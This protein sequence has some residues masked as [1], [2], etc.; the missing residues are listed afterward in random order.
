MWNLRICDITNLDIMHIL[1]ELQASRN[2]LVVAHRQLL[3][4][5]NFGNR[6]NSPCL[7]R[8]LARVQMG[9]F[10]AAFKG[11]I[12]RKP[13]TPPYLI[14]F[15]SGPGRPGPVFPAATVREIGD[16]NGE[17]QF[18]HCLLGLGRAHIGVDSHGRPGPPSGSL[19]R[20]PDY[21]NQVHCRFRLGPCQSGG[22]RSAPVS[23][24]T[25][26]R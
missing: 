24:R 2:S 10:E 15:A 1:N 16:E 12:S 8:Q 5:A 13:G 7:Y 4:A 14:P 3:G 21:A 23:F 18:W 6:T 20:S 17:A 26:G 11:Q 19:Q 25:S 22:Q 9:D